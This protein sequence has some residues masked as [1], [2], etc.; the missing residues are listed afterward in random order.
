MPLSLTLWQH[1]YSLNALL[2]VQEMADTFGL[3]C[4]LTLFLAA[5]LLSRNYMLS[6][7]LLSPTSTLGLNA[8]SG[9]VSQSANRVKSLTLTS[10][11]LS[12]L[13]AM[14]RSNLSTLRLSLRK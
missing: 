8:D 9:T 11:T 6:V 3:L 12:H 14:L 2:V 10:S 4:L 1:L 13:N 5:Q 7:F